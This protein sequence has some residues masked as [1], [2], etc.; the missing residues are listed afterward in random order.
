MRTNEQNY[1]TLTDAIRRLPSY[2]PPVELW[3][4]INRSLTSQETL[5]TAIEQLPT[6]AP[7][8][9]VWER[10][11]EQLEQPANAK[12][13]RLLPVWWSAAAAALIVLSF[14]IYWWNVQLSEPGEQVQMVYSQT[15]QPTNILKADWDDDETVMQEV[16]DAFAQKASF[17]QNPENQSLLSE[18]KELNEA[19]TEAKIMMKKYGKD[20]QLVRQIAEI[21][22]QRSSVVKQMATEI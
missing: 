16:V 1:Q 21:E 2:E 15:E 17:I 22:R 12:V 7:P 10:I 20:A 8:S 13:R 18:W 4:A 6:Y 14:G 19:K 9:A 5:E 3:N 11:A